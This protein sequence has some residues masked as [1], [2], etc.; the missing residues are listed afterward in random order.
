MSNPDSSFD[1]DRGRS[2]GPRRRLTEYTITLPDARGY[3]SSHTNSEDSNSEHSFSSYNSSPCQE[4]PC[5]LPKQYQPSSPY[6]SPLVNCGIQAFPRSGFYHNQSYTSSP[7]YHNPYYNDIAYSPESDSAQSYYAQ[8]VTCPP[9]RY[10][11]RYK[12]PAVSLQRTQRPLPPDIRLSPSPAQWDHPH[13]NHSGLSRQ[14]V[15]EQLKS[16]HRR[17]QLKSPRSRSLD[18]QG[19]VRMKNMQLRESPSY[20][21]PRG[22]ER[23]RTF[24]FDLFLSLFSKNNLYYPMYCN[25]E[26]LVIKNYIYI[27]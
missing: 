15:N 7:S 5:D 9:G 24:T 20:Q 14:V 16:W 19:A 21:S 8:Q 17:S 2:R 27:L 26:G 18:R 12:D 10:E 3:Y 22:Q 25:E 6:C 4:F 11:Y 1:K 13:Y 23:V